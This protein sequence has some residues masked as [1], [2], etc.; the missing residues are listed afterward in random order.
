ME[1][2]LTFWYA[3][4]SIISSLILFAAGLAILN[5]SIL[6]RDR[7]VVLNFLDNYLLTAQIKGNDHLIQEL[8]RASLSHITSAKFV[9]VADREG[10]IHHLTLPEG[11]PKPTEK[12]I[13]ILLGF[14]DGKSWSYLATDRY[15]RPEGGEIGNDELEIRAQALPGGFR[16]WMGH[17]AE[18][19]EEHIE[20]L[21]LFFLLMV[22]AVGVSL[23]VGGLM[24][25]RFTA[26]VRA[27]E[28]TV[29]RVA[30]GR[31]AA[32]IPLTGKQGELAG[33]AGRFNSMLD[34]I[35]GLIT[36][37]KEALDNAAHDLRTPLTRMSIA[38]ERNA[39]EGD[40]EKLREALFD[41]AEESQR[42]SRMLNTLM[43]I[44]EAETGVMAL[45]FTRVD[46]AALFEEVL[47]IYEYA[48]GDKEIAL[49]AD[50]P[51][52]LCLEGD[53][54]RLR[55]VLC[56]L[57]DNAVKYSPDGATVKIFA[58]RSDSKIKIN[59][60]DKG[61]GISSGDIPHIF[62]RLYRCDRSRTTKGSGL[63][64]SLVQA[65]VQAHGGSISVKSNTGQ[66]S[67][68]TLMFTDD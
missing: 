43:D 26:S 41:C 62:D 61:M 44:S 7:Q 32:R 19:R 35:E 15:I 64:L 54:D 34:R 10:K 49:V 11:W 42:I 68:F 46:L 31:M 22:L 23:G 17:S 25:W 39:M 33:L 20:A 24:A 21:D 18:S 5:Y 13:K 14:P 50:C 2:K 47:D 60:S 51:D 6:S 45:N 1:F 55:Q 48:A 3:V 67:L 57:V 9:M 4:V 16:I 27:L 52:G 66:G 12:A 65:V 36:A 40:P 59:V 63:G 53:Q 30:S 8:E 56:N 37:M 58:E 29:D 28:A 38:I